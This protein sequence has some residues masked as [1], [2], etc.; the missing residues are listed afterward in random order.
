MHWCIW[1][2][3]FMFY[4][5]GIMKA[6]Y[7]RIEVIWNCS[8]LPLWT[9]DVVRKD[10]SVGVYQNHRKKKKTTL[11]L[12]WIW[13]IMNF[14]ESLFHWYLYRVPF[15]PFQLLSWVPTSSKPG[16]FLM[17]HQHLTFELEGKF[18]SKKGRT[19]VGAILYFM[20]CSVIFLSQNY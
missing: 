16:S 8:L 14:L 20:C 19:D 9:F 11:P 12:N 6:C 7:L 1:C 3:Y 17:L 2:I 10:Y 13:S 15:I 4:Y 18:V 5:C